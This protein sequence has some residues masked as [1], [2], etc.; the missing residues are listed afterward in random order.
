MRICLIYDCLF[1]HTVGGAERWYRNLGERLAAAGH[2]V[3]YVTLRQWDRGVD[4]SYAGVRVHTAGPRMGL[5]TKGRRRVL[6]PLVFGAGVFAHLARHG[7]SYD[8]VHT[9]S[10]PYFSLLAAGALRRLG[11]YDL[12]VDW[13]EVWSREYWRSYLGPVGGA[14]GRFVQ[15]LCVRLPQRA[16]CF[17]RLHRDRLRECGLRGEVEVLEGEYAGDLT[18]PQPRPSEPVVVFAGRHIPEKRAAALVPALGRAR[19]RLPELRGEIYGDGPERP[20]VLEA[21]AS[22]G[23]EGVVVAPGFVDAA[24]VDGALRRALCMVLPSEREGYGLVVVEASA[25]GTPSVVV[26]APDNAAVELV[27]DGENGVI[28]QSASPEHLAEAILRVHTEGL[29]LRERTCAW[30]ARNARRL[31]LEASLERV[32]RIYG[33]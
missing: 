8:V 3:T 25:R 11:R 4:P 29:A 13:H 31:S 1:P 26:P 27:D 16:F 7:R 33:G 2:D 22:E 5:Y 28:A 9:A 24:E 19:Q 30:F 15:R 10:F 6:P 17:S 14:V 21:I 18:P 20:R 23:L 12:V 32:V